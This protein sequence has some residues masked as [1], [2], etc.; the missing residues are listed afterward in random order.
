MA[1]ISQNIPS[2]SA[3]VT[4]PARVSGRED[5]LAGRIGGYT[6]GEPLWSRHDVSPCER[7]TISCTPPPPARPEDGMFAGLGGLKEAIRASPSPGSPRSR[8]GGRRRPTEIGPT[9]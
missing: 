3:P 4:R 9:P 8:V 1:T 2:R 5:G 6:Q 7:P